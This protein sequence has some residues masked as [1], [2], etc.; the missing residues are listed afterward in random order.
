VCG[1]NYV[2]HIVAKFISAGTEVNYFFP[3]ENCN[4]NPNNYH[5]GNSFIY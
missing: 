3:P 5:N 1:E 2:L 4:Q